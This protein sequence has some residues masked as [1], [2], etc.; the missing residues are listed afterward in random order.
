MFLG[1]SNRFVDEI[2]GGWQIAGDATVLSQLFGLETTNWGPATIPHI[3]KHKYPV[4]D[5]RSGT[6]L[7][8]YEYF[9][10]YIA[11]SLINTANGVTG[12]PSNYVPDQAPLNANGTNTVNVT[13][14]NGST[15][16]N[17]TYSP[18][19]GLHPFAKTYLPGPF[20]WVADASLFKV[21]PI[22][23]HTNL[24]INLDA[25]NLFNVQGYNNPDSTTGIENMTSSYNVARQMQVTARFTF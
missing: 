11:P 23:E 1:S 2:V 3:N 14:A 22:T 18:G 17:V 13:L 21:F 4:N 8:G 9:N 20:N 24:R 25:F 15:V 19:P 5:C 6:C 10:G 16:S 12:L 7:K